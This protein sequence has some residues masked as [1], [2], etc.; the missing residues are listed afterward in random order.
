MNDRKLHDEWNELFKEAEKQYAMFNDLNSI[1][2]T[3]KD[4]YEQLY[5]FRANRYQINNSSYFQIKELPT[6]I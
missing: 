3:W 4:L 2:N 6:I 5:E 1:S